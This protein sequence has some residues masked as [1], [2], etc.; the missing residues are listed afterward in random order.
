MTRDAQM[1]AT[2]FV[3]LV[4][5]NIARETDPSGLSSLPRF[6]SLAAHAYSAPAHRAQLLAEWEAGLRTL[7]EESAPGSDHQLTFVRHYAL[8]AR[9]DAAVADLR[10]LLDGSRAPEGLA[11]DQDL[12]WT[13]LTGLARAGRVDDAEIVSEQE[14]D[15]TIVGQERAAAVRASRPTAEAKAAAWEAVMQKETPNE[16]S[17]S[18]VLAFMRHGQADVLAPYLEKYLDAA[19]T[20]W[21]TLGTHKASVVLEHIFPRPLAS[22]ELLQRV[23]GWLAS[24]TA[25]AGVKRYVAEGRSDVARALAAQ[26]RDARG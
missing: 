5:R 16:T 21:E 1:R 26:E 4:L 9:S 2:D 12:R 6:A 20:M 25:K 3:H 13:L 23:D 7:V 15:G 11:L 8:S 22:P 17:R 24:S 19:E 18:I 14:R 10:A